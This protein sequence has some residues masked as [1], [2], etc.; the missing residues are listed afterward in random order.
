MSSEIDRIVRC[1]EERWVAI[2]T[3]VGISPDAIA[4][5]EAEKAL[6]AKHPDLYRYPAVTMAKGSGDII[7]DLEGIHWL[8]DLEKNTGL[9]LKTALLNGE[10]VEAEQEFER[11]FASLTLQPR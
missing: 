11:P 4:C 10:T 7:G 5:D 1:S 2:R 3:P 9:K 6:R 8:P